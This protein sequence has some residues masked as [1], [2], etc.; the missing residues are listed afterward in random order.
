MKPIK[1]G[2]GTTKSERLLAKLADRTFLDLWSYP[3]T[4]NDRDMRKGQG[5]ELCDL[6]V[7]CGRD[8]LIFSDKAIDWPETAS[9]ELSWSRWYRRAIAHSVAQIRGAER[10]LTRFP[11]RVFIDPECQTRLPVT[12][13]PAEEMRVHGIAVVTGARAAGEAYFGKG[14]GDLMVS[15]WVKGAAHTETARED[16]LPFAVGDVDP[17]GSFIH[18]FDNAALPI[19]MREM[20]TI[21][22]FVDYL[23]ARED[24]LRNG[25][26]GLASSEAELVAAYLLSTDDQERHY[27]PK[28]PSPHNSPYDTL[29]FAPGGYRALQ[30]HPQYQAKR[31]ADRD[32]RV[33]DQLILAFSGHLLAGTSATVAGLAPQIDLAE[34]ALRAMA[35]ENR[36]SRRALGFA[37]SDTLRQAERAGTDRFAR[38]VMP[39]EGSADPQCGYVFLVVAFRGS[40]LTKKGYDYYREGRAAFLKAYCQVVLYQNRNLKRMVGIAL[41]ASSRVTGRKGGSE[42]LLM[43]EIP[44]WSAE[45]EQ[46]TLELQRNG[47]ILLPERLRAAKVSTDEFPS[48]GGSSGPIPN[49]KARR[50]AAAKAGKRRS[51]V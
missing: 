25:S 29:N 20:D 44:E 15:G 9:L 34:R 6:L 14:Q 8:V 17:M 12:L 4:F 37:F 24:A 28:S 30:N 47:E 33:W 18:V 51:R 48:Y 16:F 31:Q 3:N 13:P 22:D 36:T 2:T 11:G 5:K 46:E 50:A 23:A 35:A 38:V 39:F 43:I 32:S 49:R 41:D 27:I 10:W 21:A 1:R 45:L 19:V 7:V 42:D 40:W 26:V